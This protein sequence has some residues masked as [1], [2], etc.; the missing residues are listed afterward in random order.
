MTTTAPSKAT[1][2]GAGHTRGDQTSRL[3]DLFFFII[4]FIG[5]F[6]SDLDPLRFE[7]L[8]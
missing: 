3:I 5:I 6:C 7:N 8:A 4:E 2:G 1:G